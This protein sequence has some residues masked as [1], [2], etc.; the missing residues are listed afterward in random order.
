MKTIETVDG[1]RDW[2]LRPTILLPCNGERIEARSVTIDDFAEDMQGRD[3]VTFTCPRCG[4]VHRSN[5]YL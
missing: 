3:V 2:R 4:Q 5:V 1:D